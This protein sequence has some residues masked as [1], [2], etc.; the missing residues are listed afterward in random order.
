MEFTLVSI[1]FVTLVVFYLYL[2]RNFKYWQKRGIPCPNGTIPGIGHMWQFF[3][4]KSSF[5]DI[6]K[7]LYN[8][9]SNHSMVGFY[10][11]TSPSLMVRDPELVKTVV[12]TN[13]TS[14]H[15]NTMKVDPDLDPLLANNPFFSYGDKWMTGRKRLTYAFSSMRL[16]ILLES[17]K[18]A[19][20]KFEKFLDRRLS[21]TGKAEMELKDLF[22][23]FTAQVV[24]GAGFGVDGLCFDDEKDHESFYAMGKSFLAPTTLNNIISTVT[25]F[26]PSLSKILRMSFLP[27]SADQ[28]FRRVVADVIEQR[29]KTGSSSNDF[30]QLM[31][32]LERT[33]DEK[34]DLNVLT[35]HTVSFFVDGYETSSVTLS[36]VGFYLASHPKVQ[37]KLRE[38]VVSVLNK[39]DGIITYEAVKDMTYMDQVINESMRLV[40]VLGFMSKMCTEEFELKGSDGLACR[41]KPGTE[42][43]IP[44]QGLHEDPRYWENPKVFDPERFS[45]ERKHTIQKFVFLPFGEGPRICVGMRM[46]QLQMKACLAAFLRKFSLELSPKTQL[47]LKLC[48]TFLAAPKGGLWAFIRAI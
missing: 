37:E 13:F 4:M 30:L 14:F 16:K 12:Q 36:F 9:H 15:D 7:K 28:F 34:I 10:N 25:F 23:R 48:P 20:E 38:E 45:P 27:K 26:M 31:I 11:F 24:A 5:G 21:K 40:H 32:E 42:I 44:V 35:S 18:Q 22:G 47:P 46:A 43:V 6:C 33:E 3:L 8:D 17:V 39:Y 1:V 41:V 19:C 29:R 2:T